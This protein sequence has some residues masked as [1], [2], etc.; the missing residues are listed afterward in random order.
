MYLT[1]GSTAG[2]PASA[3]AGV[4][5]NNARNRLPRY[6]II[7]AFSYWQGDI[8]DLSIA[9]QRHFAEVPWRADTKHPNTA[10]VDQAEA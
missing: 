3:S 1:V 9:G 6:L 2:R 8:N 4:L 7:T 5:K 10:F